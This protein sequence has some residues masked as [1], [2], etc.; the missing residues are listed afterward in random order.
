MSRAASDWAWG[1][2]IKPA[3]AK[4]LLLAMAD[5]ADEN[6]KCFPSIARLE[7]DTSLNRKTIM[8][9]LSKLQEYGVILDTGERKGSTKSVKVYQLIGVGAND[10]DID[11]RSSTK[12]GT[13][14]E[15]PTSE[16]S[17]GGACGMACN[18][19]VPKLGQLQS[20][21]STKNGTPSSTKNG[22]QNQSVN[23]TTTATN[24]NMT[25]PR[26]EE[27]QNQNRN[28]GEGINLHDLD[29]SK[30]PHWAERAP[31]FH[32]IQAN[33]LE[34]WRKF[35]LHNRAECAN[36]LMTI[37]KLEY[38]WDRW[39]SREKQYEHKTNANRNN[40]KAQRAG[41][42]TG[43]PVEQAQRKLREQ[44]RANRVEQEV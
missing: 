8:A 15:N 20:G 4:L 19:G 5:R 32:A 17:G 29:E 33:H 21:S 25:F 27:L 22:T 13:A 16:P 39:V 1:K 10:A 37:S 11:V 26:L 31:L 42:Q 12:I 34:V 3:S 14:T 30:I 43:T 2:N 18:E 9:T 7:R 28:A 38:R 40:A 41:H 44:M 35:V 36:E 6:H 24:G 23:P